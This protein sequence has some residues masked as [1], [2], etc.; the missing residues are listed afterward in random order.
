MP[1]EH[2]E[3]VAG[4][5]RVPVRNEPVDKVPPPLKGKRD[6]QDLAGR[7]D[8]VARLCQGAAMVEILRSLTETLRWTASKADAVSGEA[9]GRPTPCSAWDVRALLN[10]LVGGNV[11]YAMAVEGLA[12]DV[13]AIRGNLIAD[14]PAAAY[15]RTADRALAAW[16]TADLGAR[17]VLPYGTMPAAFSIRTHLLD[18]L[19][20][21]WDLTVSLGAPRD[22]PAELVGLVADIVD[23]LPEEVRTSPQVFGAPAHV[24][25]DA[26]PF[27]R[28][29]ARCGRRVP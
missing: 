4:S 29:A 24:P 14:D 27:D 10:H 1:Q 15:R 7:D 2:P 11:M 21:G 19:L 13:D 17:I 8:V 9:L 16:R 20:H 28:L 6:H 12:P 23:G 3:P 26:S 5:A 22:A 18:H 25:D